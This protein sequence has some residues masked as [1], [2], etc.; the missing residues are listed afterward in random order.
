MNRPAQSYAN[1][2]S[3]ARQMLLHGEHSPSGQRESLFRYATPSVDTT[4]PKAVVT[5]A[6][7][8]YLPAACC[9]LISCKRAGKLDNKTELFL[10]ADCVPPYELDQARL[11]LNEQGVLVNVISANVGKLTSYHVSQHVTMSAYTRLHLDKFFSSGWDRILY[12]DADTRVRAPLDPLFK[13]DLRGKP[14]G[15]VYDFLLY[16]NDWAKDRRR[17]LSLKST[18]QYFN[19]GVLLFDWNVT[20]REGILEST[21]QFASENREMCQFWDQDALNKTCEE[22]WTPLDPAWNFQTAVNTVFSDNHLSYPDT[23]DPKISHYISYAK[24]WSGRIGGPYRAEHRWYHLT[25]RGSPWPDFVK[26]WAKASKG[27]SSEEH[28][29]RL[30]RVI[31]LGR[32]AAAVGQHRLVVEIDEI[33]S[34]QQESTEVVKVDEIDFIQRPPSEFVPKESN[35][36]PDVTGPNGHPCSEADFLEIGFAELDQSLKWHAGRMI[37]IVRERGLVAVA[38]S[39]LRKLVKR[40]DVQKQ[41]IVP[42]DQ[43]LS[44]S[45]RLMELLRTR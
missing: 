8:N 16:A 1:K 42:Y 18:S 14:L 39:G 4:N 7:E 29:S 9:A 40:V 3:P 12:L 28:N 19:S 30:R 22:L 26:S 36:Y 33:D 25:L 11:F 43:L 41:R 13:T 45:T 5:I 38:S 44:W 20:L 15:A 23:V 17:L 35:A 2:L 37:A 31:E 32:A 34:S 24:P 10:I 21:R 27:A 6:D